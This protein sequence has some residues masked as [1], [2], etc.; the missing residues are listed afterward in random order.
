M[1]ANFAIPKQILIFSE[2]VEDSKN[3]WFTSIILMKSEV[4]WNRVLLFYSTFTRNVLTCQA[5]N[6]TSSFATDKRKE[7]FRVHLSL[8]KILRDLSF[9]KF[10]SVCVEWG[11]VEWGVLSGVCW[12]FILPFCFLDS[13]TNTF[14][15]RSSLFAL[16]SSPLAPHSSKN[17]TVSLSSPSVVV[18]A[19]LKNRTTPY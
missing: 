3:I 18:V 4:L 5:R 16:R 12:V 8:D 6:I 1:T 19:P 11:C 13:F 17:L 10:Y 2:N 15:L 9:E 14:A 7:V